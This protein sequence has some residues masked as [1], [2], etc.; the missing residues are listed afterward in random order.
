[1]SPLV[2]E[3]SVGGRLDWG[4][5]PLE[6]AQEVKELTLNT[7][8]GIIALLGVRANLTHQWEVTLPTSLNE[9]SF[10]TILP[11]LNAIC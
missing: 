9:S 1:M 10:R 5:A 6:G 2:V 8:Y 11:P 4:V 7:I 3:I